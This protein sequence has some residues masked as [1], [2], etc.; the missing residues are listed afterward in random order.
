[1][2]C[3]VIPTLLLGRNVLW[4]GSHYREV[5]TTQTGFA[6]CRAKPSVLQ[7][8]VHCTG[9]ACSRLTLHH[10]NPPEMCPA[11]PLCPQ[12][13]LFHWDL[14]LSAVLASLCWNVLQGES[15]KLIACAV[16]GLFSFFPPPLFL[17]SSRNIPLLLEEC[18]FFL[19]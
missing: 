11:L 15:S 3:P 17:C 7:R 9:P 4:F 18:I 12:H 13:Q 16:L 6:L 14:L 1:M 19:V 2:E 5:L 10:R 8:I